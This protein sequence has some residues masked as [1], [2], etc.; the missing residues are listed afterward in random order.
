MHYTITQLGTLSQWVITNSSDQFVSE[1]NSLS[2]ALTY[3]ATMLVY[4][5]SIV[6][7]NEP[8]PTVTP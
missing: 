6:Y 7:V 8:V 1:Q 4:G 3:L 5:D 2:N